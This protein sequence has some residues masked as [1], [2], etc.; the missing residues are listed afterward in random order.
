MSAVVRKRR[1]GTSRTTP[2]TRRR[3]PS[4]SRVFP[5]AGPGPK[6]RSRVDAFNTATGRACASASAS[7]G[8]PSTKSKRKTFQNSP[9]VRRV[10]QVILRPS[11]YVVSLRGIAKIVL[12]STPGMSGSVRERMPYPA[13]PLRRDSFPALS[14]FSTTSVRSGRSSGP[15]GPKISSSIAAETSSTSRVNATANSETKVKNFRLRRTLSA[16]LIVLRITAPGGRRRGGSC[17]AS[18]P[19]GAGRASP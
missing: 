9:S 6:K 17:G 4:S 13:Q 15:F 5:T 19:R 8:P 18:T 10:R 14:A 11:W 12:R 1:V 2:T 3:R 7:Y 16:I